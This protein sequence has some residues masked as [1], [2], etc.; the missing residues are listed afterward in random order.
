MTPHKLESPKP[1]L[2][3]ALGIVIVPDQET[4]K[5]AY[6][7]AQEILPTGSEYVLGPGS[8]PHLTLYHGKLQ[9]LG[10]LTA[11]EV[12]SDIRKILLG[13]QFTLGSIVSFGGNFV[14]WNVDY[15]SG[16]GRLRDAHDRSLSIAQFL[17][18]TTEAKA[19]SEEALTL[20]S[21]ETE[22]VKQYGHPLVRDLYAP[23]ITLGFHRGI[24]QSLGSD[25]RKEFKFVVSSVDL[26][27]IG[28]PGRVESLVD[29]SK[30][31]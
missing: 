14:F 22:N 6:V 12:V 31:V 3:G 13:Q 11:L 10:A 20:S 15:Y 29:L 7:L 21:A 2:S 28:Y 25:L 26:A 17:D 18:R 8:I 4:V 19:T 30:A 16:M 1:T 9:G 24:A 27:R 23:H 5:S